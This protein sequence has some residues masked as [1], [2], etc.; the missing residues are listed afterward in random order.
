MD[1]WRYKLELSQAFSDRYVDSQSAQAAD[2]GT[3]NQQSSQYST[4][5][6]CEH[7]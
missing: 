7:G 5:Y 3:C 1:Q 6:W 2:K 4:L